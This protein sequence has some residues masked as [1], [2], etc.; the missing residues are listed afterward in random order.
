MRFIVVLIIIGFSNHLY[1]N[2]IDRLN[3][4]IDVQKFLVEKVD[5]KWA[6]RR[7]FS[8]SIKGKDYLSENNFFRIDLDRNG[9]TDLIVR[10]IYLF[11]I[12]DHGDGAYKLS[13]VDR[14]TFLIN[15]YLLFDI[16][17]KGK[18]AYNI[19]ELP[20]LV[21]NR[22]GNEITTS[23]FSDGSS[24]VK[25]KFDSLVFKFNDLIEYNATPDNFEIE[26]LTVSTTGCFGACP[27]FELTIKRDRTV[28]FH[29]IQNNKVSGKFTGTI[30][31]KTITALNETV[32]YIKL[33][34]LKKLYKVNW[35]DDQTIVLKI[36]LTN[37]ITK[38]INDYGGIGTFGLTNLYNQLFG[39][40]DNTGWK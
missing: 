40:I 28:A 4:L 34:S 11:I 17:K 8:D 5:V 13:F 6:N 18:P 24:I 31:K 3:T 7:I 1:A 10:G 32:N 29:A 2:E 19:E 12:T 14:G 26:E 23:A 27:V 22:V 39:I 37:G 25:L 15:R 16:L 9:L 38:Q 20:I 21:V 35:T 33:K 36:K 30:D